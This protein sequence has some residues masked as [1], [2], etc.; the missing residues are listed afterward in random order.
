VS[1]FWSIIREID[2]QAVVRESQQDV[3][4]VICG[5]PGAGKRTL[6]AALTLGELSRDSA[7]VQVYDMPSDV[8]VAL[9]TADLYVYVVAADRSV[10]G[11]QR[12]HVRQLQRRSGRVVAVLNDTAGWGTT[13]VEARRSDIAGSLGIPAERI[14]AANVQDRREV[15]DRVAPIL[16]AAVPGLALP[17]G[18]RLPELREAAA[19]QLIS[20]TSRVNG[21]FAAVSSLPS[22]VPLIGGLASAGADMLVLTKNQVMLLLK[23]ALLHQRSIDDRLQVLAEV[24]P[25]VGAGFLWRSLARTLVSFVPGPFGVAPRVAV[26]YAGT[27]VLGETAHAYY[28]FGRRPSPEVLERIR[29]EAYHQLRLRLGR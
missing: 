8:P 17:L 4:V 6:A 3:R 23:L 13:A 27:Y 29:A 16:L 12:E 2:P 19:H 14:V 11:A 25:V 28:R 24:A 22:V 15:I 7:V 1:D 9:P 5:S 20:E 26:A 10:E 21:E 18:T